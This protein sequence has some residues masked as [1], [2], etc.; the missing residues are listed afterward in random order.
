V[1]GISTLSCIVIR[2]SAETDHDDPNADNEQQYP[3]LSLELGS[4]HPHR[5]PRQAY[6]KTRAKKHRRTLNR[7]EIWS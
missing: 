2:D 6:G 4:M 3:M 5:E 1:R 7:A